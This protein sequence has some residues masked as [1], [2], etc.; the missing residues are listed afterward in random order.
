[1]LVLTELPCWAAA[2]SRKYA[3]SAFNQLPLNTETFN[4]TPK[5]NLTM[6]P[7]RQEVEANIQHNSPWVPK[8]AGCV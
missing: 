2:R 6:E 5:G 4:R 8:R 3:V 7:T 1:M